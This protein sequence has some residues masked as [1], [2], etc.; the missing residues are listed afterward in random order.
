MPSYEKSLNNGAKCKFQQCQDLADL[1][2]SLTGI[3]FKIKPV[4]DSKYGS[5]D[6]TMVGGWNGKLIMIR[7]IRNNVQGWLVRKIIKK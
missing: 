4:N 1:I 3:R 2:T 7:K 6:R 5:P